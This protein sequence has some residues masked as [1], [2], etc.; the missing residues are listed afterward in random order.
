MNLGNPSSNSKHSLFDHFKRNLNLECS[1]PKFDVNT[2]ILHSDRATKVDGLEN[3]SKENEMW[4]KVHK[5]ECVAEEFENYQH[6]IEQRCYYSSNE[7]VFE[8][9]HVQSNQY[10]QVPQQYCI[11]NHEF[12]ANNSGAYFYANSNYM[13]ENSCAHHENGLC[14][15]ESFNNYPYQSTANNMLS[16]VDSSCL[17]SFQTSFFN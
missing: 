5:E 10:C 12:I 2:G 17:P 14:N 9:Q 8:H 7:H 16:I 1:I 15:S 4:L 3:E 6:H 11:A 13:Y